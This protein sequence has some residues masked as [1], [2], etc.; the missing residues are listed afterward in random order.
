LAVSALLFV[1]LL[2]RL[3]VGT[4]LLPRQDS[5]IP[6]VDT[7][8][9]VC[10]MITAI[11]LYAQYSVVRSRALLALAMGYL[12]TAIIIV[13]HL[14]TFPGV[15]TA[16]G[17]PG[18]GLQ[19]T[20][21]LY[22]IW[23]LGLPSAAI[24]YAL[25]KGRHS[26]AVFRG[27]PATAIVA[28]LLATG[29]LASLL[30]WLAT[31][32]AEFL[33]TV[34]LD[35]TNA[36]SLWNNRAAPVL[37]VLS[38][39]AIIFLWRR[40]SSVLDLWLLVVIWAWLIETTLLSTT[41]S[42]F[43]L[44]WYTSR[45]FW[46]LSSGFVLLVLLSESTRLY[47]RLALSVAARERERDGQHMTAELIV[48]SMAHELHQPLSAITLNGDAAALMLS[49]SPPP[50]DELRAS[51]QDI[52]ADG[53]RAS[54]I[55]A[56]TRT[57]LTGVV[58]PMALFD[59][60]ALVRETLALME[61]DRRI[62]EVEL[63][64]QLAPQLPQIWGNRGDLQQVL[65][66]LLTNALDSMAAVSGR[67]RLLTLRT[68][69]QEPA[70]ISI[71][72]EDNGIGKPDGTGLRLAICRSIIDAHGGDLGMYAGTPLGCTFRLVLPITSI[73]KIPKAGL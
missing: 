17:A 23:H 38:L 60:N 41:G 36:N 18:A 57:M 61:I 34:M 16:T 32:G 67:P 44:V 5:F 55:V 6:I 2:A 15:F 30:A 8:L 7:I 26:G 28:S 52:S 42:R 54:E 69:A 29:A 12:F 59:V 45:A 53:R 24:G 72:V 10:D 48:R 40:R 1:A 9:F 39:T 22:V 3:P 25:F 20:A 65:M 71:Q 19:S 47:A 35:E 11:L 31:A 14:W 4:R 73:P 51:L 27:S 49:Q 64:L 13:P 68:A 62:L 66:N 37:I 21:W 46:L 43:S 50:L 33:P 58:R 63:R 70:A 56:S